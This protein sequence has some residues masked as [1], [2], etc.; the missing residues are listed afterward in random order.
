MIGPLETF[1]L[2]A[3]FYGDGAKEGLRYKTDTQC[4]ETKYHLMELWVGQDEDTQILF[5]LLTSGEF[6]NSI[7]NLPGYST[8]QTGTITEVKINLDNSTQSL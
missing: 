1:I 2:V 5:D 7:N 4:Y 8:R 6:R 3:V